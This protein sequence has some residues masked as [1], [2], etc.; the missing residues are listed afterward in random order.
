MLT[1]ILRKLSVGTLCCGA[2]LGLTACVS[3]S[4]DT[5]FKTDNGSISIALS[6]PVTGATV[7]TVSMSNAAK[8][9]ATV[10][11]PLGNLV[12]N[13]VVTFTTS[14]TLAT[15]IPASG[16]ALTNA[17]GVASIQIIGASPTAAGAATIS[18]SASVG[19]F[20]L[21]VNAGIGVLPTTTGTTG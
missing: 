6:D 1:S 3:G 15:M 13:A 21:T 19:G 10:R 12:P 8:V 20:A 9:T 2:L 7:T 18:A 11:D 16:T 14:A 17:S 4:A 5:T